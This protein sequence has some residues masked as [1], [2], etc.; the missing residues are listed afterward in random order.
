MELDARKPTIQDVADAARVS[1]TSVSFAFNAPERL[2]PETVMRIRRA[3]VSLGYR[4]QT[5]TRTL[6]Q[7]RQ[8][9]LAILAPQALGTMFA[10]P[11]F[12]EFVA[13]ALTAAELAGYAAQF[14]SP[15][16]GSLA[17]AIDRSNVVGVVAIGLRADGPEAGEIRRAGIPFVAINS[18]P[19]IG[20]GSVVVDDEAGARAAADH[21]LG[22]GH[23]SFLVLS[24]GPFPSS[25]GDPWTVR[26]RR[27]SGYSGGLAAHGIVLPAAAV[28]F[29]MASVQGGAEAFGRAWSSGLRPTAVLAMCDA[30]AIGILEAARGLSLRVPRDLSIVGFDDIEIARHT[31][32]PLTTVRQ[33]TRRKGEEAI[34]M[35]LESPIRREDGPSEQLLLETRLI[36]RASTTSPAASAAGRSGQRR[37]RRGGPDP[38]DASGTGQRPTG[39]SMPYV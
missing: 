39:A 15:L 9:T 34:R 13:G 38:V 5:L 21:L 37:T 12:G 8:G 18:A 6:A 22:L 30:M 23:E 11:Y 36:I 10:N 31:D 16:H 25:A 19:S 33:P 3:A 28:E 26:A 29:A 7:R 4:P 2:R 35:L 27:M 32:P 1:K 20:E 24:L 17:K 14:I